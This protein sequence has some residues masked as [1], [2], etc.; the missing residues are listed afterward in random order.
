MRYFKF[1]SCEIV[2]SKY[3][4][5]L[6]IRVNIYFGNFDIGSVLQCFI[7]SFSVGPK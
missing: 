7:C 1:I 3:T 4:V 2:N 6:S 5:E